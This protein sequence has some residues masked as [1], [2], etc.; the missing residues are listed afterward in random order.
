MLLSQF[1]LSRCMSEILTQRV[2]V[3]RLLLELVKHRTAFTLTQTELPI[4][5]LY[6]C[7]VTTVAI[8]PPD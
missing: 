2:L 6:L 7:P 3:N 5:E 1:S 8:V 4:K